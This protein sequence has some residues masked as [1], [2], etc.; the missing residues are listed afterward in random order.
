M[1]LLVDFDR[2][3]LKKSFCVLTPRYMT[4]RDTMSVWEIMNNIWTIAL[5]ITQVSFFLWAFTCNCYRLDNKTRNYCVLCI[6]SSVVDFI[7]KCLYLDVVLSL[8]GYS[9]EQWSF[10][11][12]I[13]ENFKSFYGEIHATPT[14]FGSCW[15]A[16]NRCFL[17]QF[18]LWL[19]KQVSLCLSLYLFIV[20]C[21]LRKC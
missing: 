9:S 4:T 21:T 6:V 8:R 18:R 20:Y 2:I 19:T 3:C 10:A 12:M 15:R 17:H 7:L 5:K 14:Y 13:R 1:N 11:W 16:V